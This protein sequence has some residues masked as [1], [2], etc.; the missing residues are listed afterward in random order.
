MYVK[1]PDGKYIKASSG[2][3]TGDPVVDFIKRKEAF[4]SQVY[5]DAVG[6][7]TIG[8]GHLVTPEEKRSGAFSGK[9]ITEVQADDLLRKDIKAHQDPWMRRLKVPIT[10]AQKAALTSLAFNV[11]PSGGKSGKGGVF[12]IVDLLN[13]GRTKEA[14]DKFLQ[15]DKA[16]SQATNQ[17]VQLPALAKRRQQERDVFL[18][19]KSGDALYSALTEDSDVGL[20]SERGG[21]RSV[22]Q[23]GVQTPGYTGSESQMLSDNQGILSSMI[24]LK[25]R[26]IGSPD[27][28]SERDY[29]DRIREE[30]RGA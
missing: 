11:G 19:D 4:V 28:L 2:S 20:A 5:L 12:G 22:R 1:T 10:D 6:K 21:V 9:T 27:Y 29:F 23:Q 14:A 30:G 8:F 18:S 7:E 25:I 16:H 17:V 3:R 26:I 24:Q 13:E 15:Y